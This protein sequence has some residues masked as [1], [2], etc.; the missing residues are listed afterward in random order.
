MPYSDDFIPTPDGWSTR[1]S[2]I[3][4]IG[5][6]GGGCNAVNEMFRQKIH[7]VEFIVCNTDYQSLSASDVPDKIQLGRLG[8]GMDPEKGRR[9]ATDNIEKFRKALSDQTEMV[10]ITAGMGGGTGTGAAPVIAQVAKELGKLTVGVVTL[11]FRDEGEP[12]MKRAILGI[13]ELKKYVDSL[14]IIDNQKLY[15]VFE[16]LCVYDAFPKADEVLSNAVK[17]I[18]EIITCPGFIKLDFSDVKN[19]MKDSGMAI[20]GTGIASGP[21][22]AAKAVEMAF[23]S[24]LLNDCD[25]TTATGVLVNITSS[26]KQGPTM[27]ELSQIVEYVR[28]YTGTAPRFK[29]GLVIDDTLEDKVSVTVVATGFDIN[30]LPDLDIDDSYDPDKIVMGSSG[31]Y[32]DS[33]IPERTTRITPSYMVEQERSE[34]D[35]E[36]RLS[37]NENPEK[38]VVYSK[39][40]PGHYKKPKGKPVLI[41]EPGDDIV[42]LESEPAIARA[43]RNFTST[44]PASS[45]ELQGSPLKVDSIN[46]E[47]YMSN[48]SYLHQTQD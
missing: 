32:Q 30:N 18:A 47:Q 42:K 46:G 25:L 24:P 28:S 17:S 40:A 36:E 12:F 9:A 48:N 33:D 21:D 8:A 43:N 2:I 22:R 4:V 15:N 29:R 38:E 26:R 31:I 45:Q 39:Y 19:V 7:N 20:M 16:N 37:E 35:M 1:H 34:Q 13:R 5:V 14:L 3:K 10:F 27:S 23:N 6:G 41:L 11:P 44:Q